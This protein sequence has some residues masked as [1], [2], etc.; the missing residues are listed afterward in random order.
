MRRRRMDRTVRVWWPTAYGF[1]TSLFPG[2]RGLPSPRPSSPSP[3]QAPGGLC[4]R[5]SSP[6]SASWHPPP[7]EE[8]KTLL[9]APSG[10]SRSRPKGV[11]PPPPPWTPPL[12]TPK[13]SWVSYPGPPCRATTLTFSKGH[14]ESIRGLMW[15]WLYRARRR[16]TTPLTSS[17]SPSR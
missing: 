17:T 15:P 10:S 9:S 1:L 3:A 2:P 11:S 8:N 14:T 16:V 4:P 5:F 7:G 13:P 12:V 6:A